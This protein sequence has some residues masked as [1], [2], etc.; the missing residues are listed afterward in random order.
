MIKKKLYHKRIQKG[1]KGTKRIQKAQKGYK[2][3]NLKR[4]IKTY[5][6]VR[7]KVAKKPVKIEKKNHNRS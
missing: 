1:Y 6:E 2:D 4:S 3:N 7:K 5:Q